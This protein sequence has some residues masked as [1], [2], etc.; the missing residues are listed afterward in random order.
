M[1]LSRR[2]FLGRSTLLGFSSSLPAFLGQT[3]RA[4]PPAARAGARET[5]LVVVQLTGGNDGLNTVIPY[6]DPEYRK[7]R[8]TIGIAK[9][10]VKKLSDEL[11][12]HPAMAGMADL[13]EKRQLSVIQAVGYP[14][15]SQSHFRSMDIWQAGSTE[16]DLSE[17]W[18]GR[19]MKQK[20]MTGFHLAANGNE[21]A[22]LALAGAPTR[23]PS[24]TSLADFQLRTAAADAAD[25]KRQR[26]LISAA[27][28]A[29][30]PTP[31]PLL[32]FV[33][34]TAAETYASSERLR[35]LSLKD[36]ST[37]VYPNTSFANRLKL[38][39]QLIDAEVG[40]RIVYLSLDGF[41]T[42]AGQGGGTGVH[43]NLLQTLSEGIAAFFRDLSARGQAERVCL[44]TFSEFGRRARENGSAGTDH[45]S[46]APMFL[47]G[48]KVRAGIVGQHP[49]LTHL[50]AGNLAFTIDFRR[51]YAAILTD[52][53][54]ID[55]DPI[56]GNAFAKWSELFVS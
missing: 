6:A 39:A 54:G 11:G 2:D 8:P 20:A 33:R 24:L 42:H 31:S 14:N 4:T 19:A 45:G 37:V 12:L 27:T 53:L 13:Y 51:I 26:Q 1:S 50:D 47:I 56:V 28:Q 43:A 7:L 21:T 16:E 44:M 55:S 48:P 3:A 38:A 41:D 23:V 5:I 10:D 32:N 15:P 9:P 52:W 30:T 35:E 46:A 17:G 25:Q 36:N 40:A 49:S 18:L 29:T 34:R 22:P